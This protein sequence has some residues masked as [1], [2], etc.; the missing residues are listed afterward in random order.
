MNLSDIDVLILCGGKGTRLAPVI[1]DDIPKC[2]APING[3]PFIEHLIEYLRVEGIKTIGLIAGHLW[4]KIHDWH[5]FFCKGEQTEIRIFCLH[6]VQGPLQ[7]AAI[8]ERSTARRPLRPI[9]VLNGDTMLMGSLATLMKNIDPNANI[10]YKLHGKSTGMYRFS[11]FGLTEPTVIV[12]QTE[13]L[14]PFSFID[15]GTPEGYARAQEML[16]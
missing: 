11:P 12:Q 6:E 13:I 9:L 2:L 10:E 8:S 3:R 16:K 4:S 1:G 15:I 7:D 14:I 5:D